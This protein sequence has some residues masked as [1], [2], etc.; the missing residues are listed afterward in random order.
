[1]GY[2]ESDDLKYDVVWSANED[3]SGVHEV[4]WS[5]N[6]WWP[7]HAASERL[8]AAEAALRWALE[9]RLI[10]L[11]YGDSNDARPLAKH[12]CDEALRSWR[13]W[14]IHDGPCLFFWR[15][16]AGE[17]FIRD[18]P[19]PRSWVRRAWSGVRDD[20]GDTDFPDLS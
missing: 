18:R 4:L 7:Q 11:Y 6:A 17:A 14:A 9:R 1:M 13:S 15:T 20:A 12:E 5:A 16:E 2:D 3:M 19:V 10:D 8:R